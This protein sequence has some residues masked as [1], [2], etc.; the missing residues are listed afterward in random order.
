[1]RELVVVFTD[2]EWDDLTED[3]EQWTGRWWAGWKDAVRRVYENEKA[4]D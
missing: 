2:A 1:M 3:V 4:D